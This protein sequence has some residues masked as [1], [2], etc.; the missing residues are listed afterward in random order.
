MAYDLIQILPEVIDVH[1]HQPESQD[2]KMAIGLKNMYGFPKV[3]AEK[4][5]WFG[6][7]R[8][9]IGGKIGSRGWCILYPIHKFGY[10]TSPTL[11]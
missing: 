4:A 2:W 11:P 6:L 8:Y 9:L 1:F 10:K 7:A 3:F 5:I